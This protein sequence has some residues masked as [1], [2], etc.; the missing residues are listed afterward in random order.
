MITSSL[1]KSAYKFM[2]STAYVNISRN[3]K[4]PTLPNAGRASKKVLNSARNPRAPFNSLNSRPTRKIRNTLGPNPIFNP[5]IEGK[6]K[7]T[8]IASNRF[9]GSL[10]YRL[11]PHASNFKIASNRN[12][13]EKMNPSEVCASVKIAA[14]LWW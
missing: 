11:G 2:P 14:W 10:Q 6:P 12:T 5:S 1:G 4:L 8:I 9:H 3:N 13:M 7:S